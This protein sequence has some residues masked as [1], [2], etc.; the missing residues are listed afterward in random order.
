MSDTKVKSD[1]TVKAWFARGDKG[2]TFDS[3]FDGMPVDYRLPEHLPAQHE[4]SEHM[5]ACYQ[6]VWMT[7]AQHDALVAA[8]AYRA[9]KELEGIKESDKSTYLSRQMKLDYAALEAE[10]TKQA[11]EIPELSKIR[12][13]DACPA[14]D[15]R[16]KDISK[17]IVAPTAK[18]TGI[19]DLMLVASGDFTIGPSANYETQALFVLDWDNVGEGDVLTGTIIANLNETVGSGTNK[20]LLG[21][22][23]IDGSGFL[24]Q[25]GV[26]ST[27]V[28]LA[29]SAG[30]NGLFQLMNY[31]LRSTATPTATRSM[32]AVGSDF[33]GTAELYE[34]RLNGNGKR[35]HGL[36]TSG[37]LA[38]KMYGSVIKGCDD[39]TNDCQG[40]RRAAGTPSS[41]VVE[42]SVLCSNA[43]NIV[44]GNSA[45]T[46]R[47][48]ASLS[49]R[50]AHWSCSG[51]GAV[52]FNCARTGAGALGSGLDTNLV[53]N[54]VV[55]NEFV[56]TNIDDLA[57][58]YKCK[59]SGTIYALGAAPELTENT[60]DG[61]GVPWTKYKQYPIGI[62]A[63]L[64]T[65]G[66]RGTVITQRNLQIRRLRDGNS[67]Q[68]SIRKSGGYGSARLV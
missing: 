14:I 63:E 4:S 8:G 20:Q 17:I 18:E 42:N 21:R 9:N 57:N 22:I 16:A 3:I 50:T 67:L 68:R 46:L 12:S 27:L 66:G 32:I 43:T 7:R 6:E 19:K 15:L 28:N 61:F 56:N 60:T 34:F 30:S 38:V 51:A 10:A 41:F 44:T 26:D 36:V 23:R 37:N 24:V 29:F 49:P 52:S 5:K 65:S 13:A 55:A 53:Q 64:P 2:Q 31:R 59:K 54:V 39:G 58:G 11:I 47:S 40:I 1:N 45:M 35:H 62:G 33:A 25:C 48:V